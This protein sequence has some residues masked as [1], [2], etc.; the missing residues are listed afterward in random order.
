MFIRC[1]M[2]AG[3]AGC[4]LCA[5][6]SAQ[7]SAPV[8]LSND[9]QRF[10][11][12]SNID[13][14]A[15]GKVHVVYNNFLDSI[16]GI[17]YTHNMSGVWSV[18]V[19]L[20]NTG[21]KPSG[22]RIV[23]DQND[24]IHVFWGKNGM[25]ETT[26]PVSGG[27][28]SAPQRLDTVHQGGWCISAVENQAGGIY[29]MWVRLFDDNPGPRNALWG[30]Y[31]PLNGSWE[32]EE[33][34]TTGPADNNFP[35]GGWLTVRGNDYYVTYGLSGA[36]WF[37]VRPLNGTWGPAVQTFDGAPRFAWSPT[38]PN[39]MA[40][41]YGYDVDGSAS[42]KWYEVFARFSYDHGQSWTPEF[43]LSNANGLDRSA[44]ITYDAAGNFHTV[45]QGFGCD[46]CQPDMIYRAR[47]G[48]T[49]RPRQNLTNTPSRTGAQFDAL[50]AQGTLLWFT[51]S[52]NLVDGFEDVYIMNNPQA[53]LGGTGNI[54][55]VVRDQYGQGVP[56]VLISSSNNYATMSGV[57]GGYALVVPGGSYNLT[58]SKL[59]FSSQSAIN[60]SVSS[61]GQT[62]R[63][64]TISGQP[65]LP[66][67]LT[68]AA[69]S[70]ERIDLKWTSSTSSGFAGT[71]IRYRTDQPPTGPNDG[72]LLVVKGGAPGS[73]Q[74]HSRTGLTNGVTYYYAAYAYREDVSNY[75]STSSNI[76]GTPSI[77]P[78]MDRDGDV[79]QADF[80]L[81]QLC[82]TG[83][84]VAQPLPA[85]QAA[86]LDND[87]DVDQN[88][89][90]IFQS[91]MKG[92]GVYAD[93]QCGS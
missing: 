34:I 61:G 86:R 91:C 62:A 63:D 92:P 49:W 79:D 71:V 15:A 16:G 74:T 21:G 72:A 29:F 9:L 44:E 53:N 93:P 51:Y 1:W 88:D 64:F 81:F 78:D 33:L 89:F 17:W 30:R 48:G 77:K 32:A 37:R 36:S 5:P 18:P 45:W 11:A 73:V 38:N 57:G 67:F 14:D 6:A 60:I 85:C 28:W 39:E 65:P 68:E 27:A 23:V 69:V 26:K 2:V 13:F 87:E 52:D 82:L 7:W 46:G 90:G 10:S 80:G 54:S 12:D 20:A 84:S 41:V 75:Y 25:W 35:G 55:G 24:V 47:I 42:G 56:N 58:A 8:D 70:S 4:L 31:K 3:I 40:V 43:N 66:S 59:N 19:Q 76:F 50:V 22:P 83:P